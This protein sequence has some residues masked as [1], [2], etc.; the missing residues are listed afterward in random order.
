MSS[1]LQ[2]RVDLIENHESRIPCVIIIDTSGSMTGEPINEVNQGIRR[3]YEEI[4]EDELTAVRADIALIAFNSQHQ[5]IQHF[6]QKIDTET[7]ILTASGGTRIAPPI[8]EALDIIE[9]RKEQY[10]QN[11]IPYY[12]PII[13]LVTDGKPEHDSKS[14]LNLV[15]DRIKKNEESKH[16]TFF[17]VGTESADMSSLEQLSNLPPKTLRGTRFVSL[18]EWLSNSITAISNSQL[19]SDGESEPTPLPNTNAWEIF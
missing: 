8:N 19:N 14:D 16:L 5:I 2:D 6:G 9:K 11:G 4:Q 1:Q 13:M 18:F 12:R 7:M 3:F 17:A 15:S 10:R